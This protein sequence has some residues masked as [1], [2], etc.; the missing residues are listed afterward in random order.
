MKKMKRALSL[1]AAGVMALST[2]GT[3][4]H[5]ETTIKGLEP[6]ITDEGNLWYGNQLSVDIDAGKNGYTFIKC[7]RACS[8]NKSKGNYRKRSGGSGLCEN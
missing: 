6:T 7:C 5:A 1:M 2:M 3:T 4:V 8:E